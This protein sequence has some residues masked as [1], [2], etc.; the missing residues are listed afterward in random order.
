MASTD[1]GLGESCD[2]LALVPFAVSLLRT[3]PPELRYC[4][5]LPS[6][7]PEGAP[8]YLEFRVEDEAAEGTDMFDAVRRYGYLR[9]RGGRMATELGH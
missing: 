4:D 6:P 7:L 2:C 9:R 1:N 8:A 3:E 5:E